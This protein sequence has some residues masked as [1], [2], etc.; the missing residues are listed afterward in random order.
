M[1][2]KFHLIVS[3]VSSCVG[4]PVYW[5]EKKLKNKNYVNNYKKALNFSTCLESMYHLLRATC[6]VLAAVVLYKTMWRKQG[7]TMWSQQ[8]PGDLG[9]DDFHQTSPRQNKILGKFCSLFSF[10]IRILQNLNK[11]YKRKKKRSFSILLLMFITTTETLKYS[12]YDFL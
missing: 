8:N 2:N 10:D 9:E 3:K 7:L 11:V 4:N 6:L 1:T 5:H 12:Q